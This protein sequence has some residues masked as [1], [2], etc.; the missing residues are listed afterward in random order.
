MVLYALPLR[1]AVLCFCEPLLEHIADVVSASLIVALYKAS[2]TCF[3]TPST[4]M[5]A[6]TIVTAMDATPPAQY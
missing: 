3:T 4:L 1:A 5:S 2:R 6:S